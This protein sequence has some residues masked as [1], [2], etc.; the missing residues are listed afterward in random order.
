MLMFPVAVVATAVMVAALAFSAAF[1]PDGDFTQGP[2]LV[3]ATGGV[4]VCL[5]LVGVVVD[6]W[7]GRRQIR[8]LLSEG[9]DEARP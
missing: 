6:Y 8:G 2:V 7:T 3:T 1:L 4:A 9:G 5:V